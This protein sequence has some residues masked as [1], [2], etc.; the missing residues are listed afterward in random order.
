MKKQILLLIS[1]LFI[2]QGC[3]S[4]APSCSSSDVKNLVLE[5][6]I[7]EIQKALFARFGGGASIMYERVK[8]NNFD[9]IKESDKAGW[10]Q[11]REQYDSITNLSLDSIRTSEVDDKLLKSTCEGDLNLNGKSFNITYDA[12]I[13]D[14]GDLYV[15]VYGL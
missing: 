11:L 4:D 13:T 1:A 9:G 7:E 15:N 6:S 14:E 10:I 5:I 12:Q 2:F 8:N 3:S